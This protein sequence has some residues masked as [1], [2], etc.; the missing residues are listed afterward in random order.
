MF[1]RAGRSVSPKRNGNSPRSGTAVG[2][3]GRRSRMNVE[4]K[5]SAGKALRILVTGAAGMVGQ[6][7]IPRLLSRGCRVTAV[8]KNPATLA[9][10]SARALEARAYQ[11]DLSE[12]GDWM[13]LL[14]DCDVVVDL[15]AQITSPDRSI[16]MRN[17]AVATALILDACERHHVRHLIHLSSSVVMSKANDFYTESKRLG[18]IAVRTRGVPHTILRPPLMYGPGDIKHL[19]LILGLMEKFPLIPIPGDGRYLRQPLHVADLCSVIERVLDIEPEGSALNIIG[20]DRIPF[21]DLLRKI[22][23]VRRLKCLLL[24]TPMVIFRAAL[25]VQRLFLR[26]QLFTTQQLEA[27]TAGDDFP[28]ENWSEVFSVSVRS[29]AS[30]A[31][32]VYGREDGL[33]RTL[34]QAA[35]SLR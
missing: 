4:T 14:A 18:E 1:F 32:E 3:E 19:G 24:P 23:Q 22:R 9:V 26:R 35:S 12:P 33:R 31:E 6:N 15:K 21:I 5:S 16:H 8:D 2:G 13:D 7:L 11:A 10:L 25:G 34:S 20:H 28:V 30:T 27:L 29:F 17:N